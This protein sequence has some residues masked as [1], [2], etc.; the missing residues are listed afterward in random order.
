MNNEQ[1]KE[2]TARMYQSLGNLSQSE[3]SELVDLEFEQEQYGPIEQQIRRKYLKLK[4]ERPER[5]EHMKAEVDP[6][7]EKLLDPEDYKTNLNDI[8]EVMD[9]YFSGYLICHNGFQYPTQEMINQ[10]F[11]RKA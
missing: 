10:K 5:A 1:E 2:I 9:K 8:G 4:S 11:R 3:I 6:L 7:I